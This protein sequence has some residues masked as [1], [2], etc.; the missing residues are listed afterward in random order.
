MEADPDFVWQR[1]LW[2]RLA[3]NPS[4]RGRRFLETLPETL[5][6]LAG[7]P[8]DLRELDLGHGRTVPL[9]NALHVFMPFVV[10]PP[11]PQKTGM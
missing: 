10:P 5:E 2:Q 6:S 3:D 7:A 11:T 8:R 4:W 9:P 1:A